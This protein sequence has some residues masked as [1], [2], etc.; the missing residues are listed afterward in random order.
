MSLAILFDWMKDRW[1]WNRFVICLS[2][3]CP[4]YLLSGV[5]YFQQLDSRLGHLSRERKGNVLIAR[6]G[7]EPES[8][9]LETSVMV[10]VIKRHGS[11]APVVRTLNQVHWHYILSENVWANIRGV[12]E[13]VSPYN[14]FQYTLH[15]YYEFQPS[16]D[17]SHVWLWLNLPM[18][19]T[20]TDS[21]PFLETW[22]DASFARE[23]TNDITWRT[24]G[25]IDNDSK[26]SSSHHPSWKLEIF[27]EILRHLTLDVINKGVFLGIRP[28]EYLLRIV[29]HYNLVK[30][31]LWRVIF[32]KPEYLL[33]G[34]VGN[35][36]GSSFS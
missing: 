1:S 33:V 34:W 32:R 23:R 2:C 21:C 3:F 24:T 13:I 22:P 35:R 20:G 31:G 5:Q 26:Q 28:R 29:K 7:S 9:S 10:N 30:S 18:S 27:A 16:S 14:V 15:S 25:T 19:T 8:R 17:R 11:Q 6:P 12:G 4:G 36:R